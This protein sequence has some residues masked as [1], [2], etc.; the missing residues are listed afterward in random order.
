MQGGIENRSY[1]ELVGEPL[2]LELNFTFPLEH[3]TEFMV[4]GERM[5]SVAVDKFGAVE[6]KK[7]NGYCFTPAKNQRCLPTK[8]SV[9]WFFLL[10]PFYNSWHWHFCR[11]KNATQENQGEHWIMFA[12]PNQKLN[13]ADSLGQPS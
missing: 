3:V 8:V 7:W 6:I 11:Y 10:W 1:P 4:M 9:P 13:F 5:P 12:K 2:R